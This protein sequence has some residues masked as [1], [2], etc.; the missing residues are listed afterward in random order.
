MPFLARRKVA[1]CPRLNLL[2]TSLGLALES[3]FT[4]AG[5]NYNGGVS[6]DITFS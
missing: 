3:R 1:V 6:L 2:K 5:Q 4:K